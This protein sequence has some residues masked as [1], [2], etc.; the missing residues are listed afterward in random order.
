[1]CIWLFGGGHFACK[2]LRDADLELK[3][4]QIQGII[5]NDWNKVGKRIEGIMTYSYDE[6]LAKIESHYDKIVITCSNIIY[7][8]EIL[9]QLANDSLQE[10]I[11]GVYKGNG[12]ERVESIYSYAINS[13]YGEELGLREILDR[14]FEKDYKGFYVDVGAY[15]PFKFS[16][17]KWAYDRGGHGINIEPNKKAIELFNA[18]RQR[19]IN[20]CCGVSDRNSIMPYYKYTVEACNSFDDSLDRKLELKNVIDVPIR[21]LNDILEEYHV[22]HIDFLDI[23]AE[24]FDEK[25]VDSFDWDKYRPIC[26]LV[27]ILSEEKSHFWTSDIHKKLLLNGYQFASLFVKTLL[28]VKADL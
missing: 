19:D 26:V 18:F 4:D 14:L 28:Y 5:D 23:D 9:C 1:M 7:V 16:N 27:E 22:K 11:L 25:I 10:L 15:H 17:T 12:I 6:A 3:K 13:Q 2:L 21:K 8:E 24:G 20:L